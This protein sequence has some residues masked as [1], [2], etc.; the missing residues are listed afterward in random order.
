MNPDMQ[1]E[2]RVSYEAKLPLAQ[3]FAERLS[4][5][6][7]ELLQQEN[8]SLAVP[9]EF[10]VKNWESITG[11]I[12]DKK[13]ELN[14]ITDLDDFIGL[15][16]ILLF[17]RDVE[18]VCKVISSSF[19]VV[20]SE[21]TQNRLG[22][23]EFGYQSVH[24]LIG[25]PKNWL[26]VPT[27]SKFKGFKAEVQVRTAAQHIW[28]TASHNLQ[29]KQKESVPDGVLRSINRVS[30]LLETVDL[31]F[32]RALQERESYAIAVPT[33][34]NTENLNVDNLRITLDAELP[35]VNKKTEEPY[36]ELLND[37]FEKNVETIDDLK[38]LIHSFRTQIIA[39]DRKIAKGFK[40]K[41][42]PGP[43]GEIS[44]NI[45]GA[46]YISS[47]DF[48][49]RGVFFAHVGL[50]RQMLELKYPE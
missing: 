24:F 34:K 5:Q 33:F 44:A 29:Y 43:D 13:L 28:A 10:R 18:R 41:G 1:Q 12:E 36:A 47:E 40:H 6:I 37:L 3:S 9:I 17:K 45:D 26:N 21:D 4:E 42:K 31:E 19:D 32:E 14:E 50:I 23:S 11:K 30:A 39:Q 7:L 49:N 15:R 25:L 22:I 2:L 27:F 35:E 48:I 20:E 46:R 16:I 38:D 8:L